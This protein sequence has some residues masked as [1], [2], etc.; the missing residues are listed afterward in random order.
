[1]RIPNRKSR[2]PF[3]WAMLAT[4]LL[5][6]VVFEQSTEA[7]PPSRTR[8]TNLSD[9]QI[10]SLLK[11]RIDV[12]HRGIGLVVGI[13]SPNG[14]RVIH[15]GKQSRV[16]SRNVNGDSVFEIGSV[17]KLFTAV[18]L[19]DMVREGELSLDD[20]SLQVPTHFAPNPRSR[21]ASDQPVGFGDSHIR[22][23]VPSNELPRP[24]TMTRPPDTHSSSSRSS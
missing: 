6:M 23:P 11:D 5:A 15:Y 2:F 18:I 13:I 24:K 20:S 10:R 14:K 19:A 8:T 9:A 4:C 3:T 16:H 7:Q 21:R 1:M 12:Q 17:T 22:T